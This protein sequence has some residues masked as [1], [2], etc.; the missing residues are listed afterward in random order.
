MFLNDHT[1]DGYKMA[2]M[3][4]KAVA[5]NAN[6][7][8]LIGGALVTTTR[9]TKSAQPQVRLEPYLHSTGTTLTCTILAIVTCYSCGFI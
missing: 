9:S 7:V 5:I 6:P 4:G 2:L 3:W 1:L 8:E